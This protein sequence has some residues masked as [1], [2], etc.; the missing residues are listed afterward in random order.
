MQ[1]LPLLE[2]G[3]FFHIYNR[4]NNNENIF[5][6]KR[7]Y[8]Y[9]LLLYEKYIYP[10]ADTFAFCLL[11]NHFHLFVRIKSEGEIIK[12]VNL[13]GLKNLEG[14]KIQNPTN[15]FSNLFNAYAKAINKTYNRTGALFEK[16][17]KRKL[18]TSVS[19]FLP[20]IY[21]I[22]FNPQKHGFTND[23]RDY[24]Y[25]SYKIILSKKDTRLDR[26]SVLKWFGSRE[27]FKEYHAKEFN[28]K[29]TMEYAYFE[30]GKDLQGLEDLEGL[31]KRGK[32]I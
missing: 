4:G 16:R 6:E 17:F 13:Q 14:F 7:N 11:K 5:Y 20:L 29:S 30:N 22:H 2:Y 21:Y 3:K 10:I 23:Y 18:I 25:S 26:Q 9:F 32:L 28:G 27:K 24:T 8:N 1:D 31:N 15:Q 12:S 19:Y